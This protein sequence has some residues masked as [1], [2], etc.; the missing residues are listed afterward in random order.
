M[1]ECHIA[2]DDRADRRH[3]LPSWLRADAVGML[4][5][6]SSRQR[7]VFEES[8]E[9]A[10]EVAFEA[11]GGLAAALCF[12]GSTFDV[13]DG[14]SVCS[15]SGEDDLVACSVEL[16]VAVAVESVADRLAGRGGDWGG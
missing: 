1:R 14:R 7:R 3:L 5:C 12:A 15:A 2:C 13:V 4:L 9:V 16:S 10:G 11:A 8:V 6:L